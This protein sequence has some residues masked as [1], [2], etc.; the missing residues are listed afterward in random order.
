MF[1]KILLLAAVSLCLVLTSCNGSSS[2]VTIAPVGKTGSVLG[3]ADDCAIWIHPTNRSLSLILGNDKRGGGGLYGW[4]LHGKLI[5]YYAPLPKLINLDI[6]YGFP[7]GSEKVDILVT[8][9]HTDNTLR[10]FKIDPVSRKLTD[11]TVANG[12]PT[13]ADYQISSLSL[14]Q[15][16][17]TGQTSVFISQAKS[18]ADI[19]EIVLEE[20][21]V[22]Q[23][24]G[25]VVRT[26][27]G[28]EIKTTVE[29]MCTDD[30]L[31]YL[32]CCD[33]RSSILKFYADRAQ[34]NALVNRF[35]LEDG[36][37][38]GREGIGLYSCP[39]GQGYLLV[40]TP[41][42]QELKIYE[43]SGNNRF[44]MTA[45]KKGSIETHGI[46]VTSCSL[47]HFPHGFIVCHNRKGAN[48]VLYD[49]DDIS[50]NQLLKCTCNTP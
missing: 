48:F 10:V 17:H 11:V 22:D 42:H 27:G 20:G 45:R 41:G 12:I 26:F 9:T 31:G 33:E 1:N 3:Y 38:A 15:N 44:I 37:K 46:A 34:G 40:S 30:E 4:D 5:F 14:Y 39:E 8:G 7:L 32:Y 13:G 2:G 43:R 18:H 16:P 50:H 6:R 25:T 23:V 36:I 49:W 35:A 24:Q 28:E 47:G 19:I 29:G 21:G